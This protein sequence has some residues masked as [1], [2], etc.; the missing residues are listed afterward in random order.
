MDAR[1][2][3]NRSVLVSISINL[4][5]E[6]DVDGSTLLKALNM[7]HLVSSTHR[8]KLCPLISMTFTTDFI[9]HCSIQAQCYS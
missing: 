4:L 9:Q 3:M 5:K 2:L 8:R 6:Y 7:L 1:G